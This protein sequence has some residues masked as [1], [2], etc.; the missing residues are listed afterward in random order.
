MNLGWFPD[1]RTYLL[2]PTRLHY[3]FRFVVCCTARTARRAGCLLADTV[4]WIHTRLRSCLHGSFCHTMRHSAVAHFGSWIS[5]WIVRCRFRTHCQPPRTRT[6]ATYGLRRTLCA[7]ACRAH[8]PL[9]AYTPLL[10]GFTL[11]HAFTRI[12]VTPRHHPFTHALILRIRARCCARTTHVPF[13]VLRLRFSS[14]TLPDYCTT[15]P[16]C[17]G[18]ARTY[19]HTLWLGCSIPLLPVTVVLYRFWRYCTHYARLHT[20][21]YVYTPFAALHCHAVLPG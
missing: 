13:C 8:R 4:C 5:G 16:R 11:L 21:V 14:C 20:H 2:V 1:I 3:T 19:L 10:T 9:R 17:A 15:A 7:R 12:L 18:T 6:A